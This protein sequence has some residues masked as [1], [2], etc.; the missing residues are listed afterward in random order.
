M[1]NLNEG[2]PIPRVSRD[3]VNMRMEDRLVGGCAVRHEDIECL[4]RPE[5]V[6][7][8]AADFMHQG[9]DCGS[10]LLSHARD[11]IRMPLRDNERVPR[12][13]RVAVQECQCPGGLL[14]DMGR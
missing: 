14:H 10:V 13:D 8:S 1:G 5:D 4:I 2:E 11:I 6:P 3:E 12:V 7:N 9:E